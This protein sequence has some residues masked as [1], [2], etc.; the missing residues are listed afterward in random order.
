VR[1][2]FKLGREKEKNVKEKEG[3]KKYEGKIEV[4]WSDRCRKGVKIKSTRYVRSK[5]WPVSRFPIFGPE[6]RASFHLIGFVSLKGQF[7]RD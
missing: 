6:I 3:K 5:F 1:K 4:K 2:K 7:S